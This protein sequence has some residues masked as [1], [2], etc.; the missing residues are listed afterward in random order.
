[1][2][3][4]PFRLIFFLSAVILLSSCLGTTT[5][6]VVSTDARFVSLTFAAN[7]SIPFLNTAAFTLVGKTIVN[8]DSLPYK[9]R[10]DSVNPTFKFIT[11]AGARLYGGN[12]HKKDSAVVTGTDTIDFRQDTIHIRN[13]ASDAKTQLVYYINTNV[14]QV[15]PEFYIWNKVT[16]NLTAFN[17]TNQ[18]AIVLNDKMFFYQN[19]GS[20]SSVDTSIDGINWNSEALIGL[21][22]DA[23]LKAMVQFN[24]KL[25]L[26]QGGDKIYSTTDGLTWNTNSFTN[27]DYSFKSIVLGLKDSLYAITQSKTDMVYRFASSGDGLLWV[28]KS[29][30]VVPVGFPISDFASVAYSSS[31][32]KA[33]G[34]VLQGSETNSS[35]WS[36][37]DGYYW[38]NFSNENHSLDT[39]AVGASVIAYDSKLLVFG[40]R[41]DN[42]KSYYKVSKDEG[43]SWQTPDTLRNKL[44]KDYP[45][46]T[47]QSAIVLKPRAYD[48]LDPLPIKQQSNRIFLIGGNS[49]LTIFSD[50][51]T[52]KLN[53]KNFLIQE[54]TI[55]VNKNAYVNKK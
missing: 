44:P 4:N 54:P 9:T 19:D 12:R 25:F 34:L 48:K 47:N 6:A 32:G 55:Y 15:D 5:T 11:S 20:G 1:M 28:I 7:D 50:V 17:A 43:L 21:P 3:F 42:G 53:R 51:W 10:I 24:G 41:T 13:W 52:G 33:K 39:L 35:N 2:K 27:A 23:P 30:N 16:V 38:V 46:R 40:L 8:V 29:T 18:K 45:A 37:E 14:H 22:A 31:T 49:G 26:T 36:T